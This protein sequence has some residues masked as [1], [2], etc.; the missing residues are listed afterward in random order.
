MGR[1][2]Y[3][4]RKM[5][6][7]KGTHHFLNISFLFQLFQVHNSYST[8]ICRRGFLLSSQI[9]F[10]ATNKRIVSYTVFE[11]EYGLITDRNFSC[12]EANS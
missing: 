11:D 7:S 8:N 5:R 3:C 2:V 12:K 4:K 1:E 10:S 6:K 9:S